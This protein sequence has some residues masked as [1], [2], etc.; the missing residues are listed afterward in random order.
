MASTPLML[1]TVGTN[2][3]NDLDLRHNF[4]FMKQL[5]IKNKKFL[6]YFSKINKIFMIKFENIVDWIQLIIKIKIIVMT[7]LDHSIKL[8][9]DVDPQSINRSQLN[10]SSSKMQY[11]IPKSPRF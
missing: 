10:K 3:N 11:T 4:K 1:F 2:F 5:I 9:L 6:G 8:K 7:N